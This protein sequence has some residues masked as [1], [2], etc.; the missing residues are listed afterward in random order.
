[1]NIAIIIP[2]RFGSTRFPGKPLAIIGD[3]AMIAHVYERASKA[4]QAL[5]AETNHKITVCVA[6]DDARIQEFC[7]DK[8]FNV[9]MTSQE[10]RTGSDRVLEASQALQESPKNGSVSTPD[11]A[12]KIDIVLNL[13]GDNPFVSAEAIE[14]VLTTLIDNPKA[15]VATPIIRLSWDNLD[16]LRKQK[17]KAPFS[18]TTVTVKKDGTA[19]WFSKTI[20]P[21]IRKEETQRAQSDKSPVFRHIGLYGYRLETLQKFTEMQ[22][23]HYEAL[24]GLEQ[25]RFLENGIDIA[26]AEIDESCVPPISGIDTKEDLENAQQL[27]KDGL[28]TL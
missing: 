4:Q 11:A 3:K 6:T 2:A 14:A 23:S 18:G 21:S 22:E 5:Q 8:N 10:C 25:L 19:L 28:I 24:E 9:V 7:L 20:L 13:Q 26:C 27:I 16:R 17:E 1:M 15:Q 12:N